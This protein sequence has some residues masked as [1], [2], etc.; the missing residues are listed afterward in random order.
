MKERANDQEA[1]IWY[2]RVLGSGEK[3]CIFVTEPLSRSRPTCQHEKVW[4]R[5]SIQKK[6]RTTLIKDIH[7]QICGPALILG[8]YTT[9][10]H[11]FSSGDGT[12]ST[13]TAL[14]CSVQERNRQLWC[15]FSMP[16][17][18]QCDS[19][20]NWYDGNFLLGLIVCLRFPATTTKYYLVTCLVFMR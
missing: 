3:K 11:S 12:S 2:E 13:S 9:S 18:M 14:K 10:V 19:L 7:Q 16:S 1:S 17:M 8:S 15:E 20:S 6:A 4:K 5:H